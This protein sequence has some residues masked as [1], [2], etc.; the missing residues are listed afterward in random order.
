MPTSKPRL[1]LDIDGVM[2]VFPAKHGN[3]NKL[4][5]LKAW[6]RWESF[7]AYNDAGKAFHIIW[8][9]ELVE[10][11]K[12]L[13]NIYDIYWLTNWRHL[14]LTQFTP[15]TGLPVFPVRTAIGVD[16]EYSSITS[17]AGHAEKRWWK[18]NA[19]VEDMETIPGLKWAWVDD[20]IRSP[21]RTYFKSL[22]KITEVPSLM[23]TP[24]DAIGITPDH[25]KL[26][27]DF[28]AS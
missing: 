2:V 13:S 25:L 10:E 7:T 22:A 28:A 16:E 9:P 26:L 12:T 14:A 6:S 24:F 21:V 8:S 3:P 17:L 11:I 4:P 19:I 18:V 23:V 15:N 27:H 5:H 1:Y 20:S